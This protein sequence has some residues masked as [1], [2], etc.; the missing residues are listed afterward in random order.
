MTLTLHGRSASLRLEQ[1]RA[2][3]G[4]SARLTTV[5]ESVLVP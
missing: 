4:G 3:R 1:A 2:V 5:D